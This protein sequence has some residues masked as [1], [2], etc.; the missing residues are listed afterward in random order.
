VATTRGPGCCLLQVVENGAET[1]LTI[2]GPPDP[3]MSLVD[4][5]MNDGKDRGE[6]QQGHYNVEGFAV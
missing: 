4:E 6:Q 2:A 3:A 1:H 5:F